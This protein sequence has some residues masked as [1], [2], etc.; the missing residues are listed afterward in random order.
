MIVVKKQVRV[1][2][3]C[4]CSE[5]KCNLRCKWMA[6]SQLSPQKSPMVSSR[7]LLSCDVHTVDTSVIHNILTQV[8]FSI[9]HCARLWWCNVNT[10]ATG[11][12]RMWVWNQTSAAE[13]AWNK[14]TWIWTMANMPSVK[15]PDLSSTLTGMTF[16]KPVL[17]SIKDIIVILPHIRKL[18]YLA[19]KSWKIIL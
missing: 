14:H 6:Y 2:V 10:I 19:I 3:H 13:G 8:L 7:K 1:T 4:I 17:S 5:R 9:M 11:F 18:W 15:T 16:H 12:D